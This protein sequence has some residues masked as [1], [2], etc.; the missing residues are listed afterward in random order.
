MQNHFQ[1]LMYTHIIDHY[2]RKNQ[3]YTKVYI[4]FSVLPFYEQLNVE[5]SI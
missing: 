3:K 4:K 5:Y 1:N 2:G